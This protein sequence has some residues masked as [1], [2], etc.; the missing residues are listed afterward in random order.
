MKLNNL[1]KFLEK[2]NGGDT[3]SVYRVPVCDHTEIKKIIDF[4]PAGLLAP[5][6]MDEN[7]AAR[8]ALTK[9]GAR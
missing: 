6:V 5:M 3:A 1:E 7:D 8:A 9:A 4:A 2:V